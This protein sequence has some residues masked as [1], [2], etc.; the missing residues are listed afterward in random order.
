MQTNQRK[1]KQ[2]DIF[3]MLPDAISKFKKNVFEPF[4]NN[5]YNGVDESLPLRSEIFTA[6]QL[7]HH[8]KALA[9]RHVLI[10]KDLSEQLLKRLA[11]NENILLEVHSILTDNVKQE[12]RITPAGEWLLDNFYLIEEQIYTAKKHLPKGYSKGLPQLAKGV[13]AGL[14][15]V[16][17]IAVEIISHSD[18]HVSLKSL[19]NFVSAYQQVNFL[20]LG[21]LWGIPIMLRLALLENLRRLSIQISIDITNKSLATY[22]AD[23]M[24]SVAEKD[25]KNLV[26]VIADM[27]RSKPPMASSFVAELTRRLQEKGNS[28]VL[29]MSWLEQ[30]LSENGLSSNELVQQENQKQAADQVSI[31]NSISSLR[32]LST[33]DWREFVESTSIMEETLRQDAAG[34]YSAMDFDTRDYYRHVV[35]N[36]AKK[37]NYSEQ[38][39]AEMLVQLT[40]ESVQKNDDK[41]LSHIGY[42]LRGKELKRIEKL[43]GARL[44]YREKNKKLANKFPLTIYIGGI[45]FLSVLICWALI[46]KAHIE[47]FNSWQLI[48]LSALSLLATSMV[49][50]SIVNWLV[51]ITARPGLL[52]RMDFSEGIP[53]DCRTMV[54]VPTILGS[55]ADVANL[56]EGLEVRFLAN[57]DAN[58]S[59][60]LLTD[61]KDAKQE[62]LQEDE[63]ILRK[64]GQKIIELNK[65]YDRPG[66]DTFFLFHRPRKWNHHER[67]WMGFERKRGKLGDL[68]ALIKG[69]GENFFSLIVGEKEIYSSVKY[70]ITLDTDT[71]LPRDVAW[72]MTA[73]MAHP[74][75]HPVYS[76]KKK[77]VV[78]GYTILQPRVSNSLPMDS[79]S[80]Y[81]RMHGNEP[82]TDPYTRATDRKSVV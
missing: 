67:I 26:L 57:R 64:A 36:I 77:R 50:V 45:I 14:P 68:N 10:S 17:D 60:A 55:A 29:A 44:T 20:N 13:S 1:D 48:I 27:A 15:R 6:E 71:Q 42:Y 53:V 33:T 21:E 3:E 69:E 63:M 51:T 79:S 41:R 66:N 31:S 72:K 58:L 2:K 22:W 47:G 24:I 35:E 49:A 54:V 37:S 56:T 59:F 32:F 40:K 46:G 12:S 9:K 16:Y 38:Q 8:A 34:I 65:K 43:A 62:H 18:G 81:S 74:L 4:F 52:P 39:V 61:F 28:L 7:D 19:Q 70:I 82:G 76:E 11:E 5:E 78:E 30:T 80:Y 25:P 73:T 75:N 23:E